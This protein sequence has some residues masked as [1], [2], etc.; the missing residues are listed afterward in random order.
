MPSAGRWWRIAVALLV[1]AIAAG[2]VFRTVRE[3]QAKGAT[4][5]TIAGTVACERPGTHPLV[6]V[7]VRR[8]AGETRI[9]D[10]FVLEKPGRWA[11]RAT[12][13]DYA[14][15]AFEDVDGDLH[16]DPGEPALYPSADDF[17]A[18]AEGERR[19]DVALRVPKDDRTPTGARVDIEALQARA[20]VGQLGVTLG[21]MTVAGEVASLDDPRF[22]RANGTKGLWSPVDFV[23]DVRPGIYFAA[24]Y[25]AH[26]TPVLFVHGA[27]GTPRDF[28]PLVARLD[29]TRL[30]PWFFYY[31]SGA[32]LEDV[33]ATLAG[34]VTRL[35]VRYRLTELYVVAHSMG[36]LVARAFVLEH[37]R[38]GGDYVTRLVTLATPWGGNE[39]AKRGVERAPAVVHSWR[40]LATG[41]EFLHDLFYE[42]AGGSTR[43]HLPP[44][45]RFA[46]LFAFNRKQRQWGPSDDGVIPLASQ[47]LLEAQDDAALVRGLDAT[48]A[49]ILDDPQAARTIDEFLR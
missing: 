18:L 43:R 27:T 12:A 45:V 24:P 11:F 3:Q 33:A 28:A 47:L 7:L 4:I 44:H 13:G 40:A 37:A 17:F 35:R 23:V 6:V 38:D 26:K 9:V 36:G 32:R 5:G 29:T 46:L 10:H 39:M 20:P 8:D 14:L 1:G 48:H 2:C 34:L 31:P 42:D 19:T 15:A 22:D 30:Q 25:D 49:G 21:A 41:S 16:Y